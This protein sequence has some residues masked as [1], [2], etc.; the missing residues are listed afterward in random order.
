MTTTHTPQ[1]KNGNIT[2]VA[3]SATNVLA[4]AS[5]AE[6]K[7]A[8]FFNESTAI[9]YLLLQKGTASA[10]NYTV[11]LAANGGMFKLDRF[12]YTGEVN[13]IWASANG[14][15]MVTELTA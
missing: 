11:Q 8:V 10:T 7:G 14:A 4:L 2:R 13:V 12:D 1:A 3:S 5:N 6:R 9:A 15:L